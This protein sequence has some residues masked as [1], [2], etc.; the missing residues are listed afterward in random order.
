MS[1]FGSFL[2]PPRNTTTNI[3][4]LV[5]E[6]ISESIT[7]NTSSCQTTIALTQLQ[8]LNCG[9]SPELIKSLSESEACKL[10]IINSGGKDM[11]NC[12][13]FCKACVFAGNSQTSVISYQSVCDITTHQTSEIQNQTLATIDQKAK[14]STDLPNNIINAL[15]STQT[16]TN[17]TSNISNLIRTHVSQSLVQEIV[18]KLISNQSQIANGSDMIFRGNN[19]YVTTNIIVKTLM[20]NSQYSAAVTTLANKIVQDATTDYS[21]LSWAGML[22]LGIV[23]VVVI[24]IAIWYY[25]PRSGGAA[26]GLVSPQSIVRIGMNSSSPQPSS[27]IYPDFY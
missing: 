24:A 23:I 1:F 14:S 22:I 25:S 9:A 17:N 7:K 19:Q 26:A 4:N 18:N 27:S 2:N 15:T 13:I 16:T 11:E 10:C 21:L 3:I 6:S 5:N 20:N 8:S 12:E